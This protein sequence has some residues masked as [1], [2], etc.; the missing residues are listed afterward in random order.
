MNL[1]FFIRLIFKNL[2][3]IFGVGFLMAA[4]VYLFTKNQPDTYSSNTTIYTGIATG[5]DIES[6]ANARFDLFANNAQFDN[7]IN[8]IK[9]R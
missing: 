7:L 6:G 2:L 1:V 8:I 4:L 3:L 9:S 5:Y